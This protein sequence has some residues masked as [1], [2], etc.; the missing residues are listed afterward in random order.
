MSAPIRLTAVL[1][2]PVQ[3]LAPLFRYITAQCPSLELTVLYAAI[4]GPEQQGVGFN[5]AFTW[6]VPLTDGY[7]FVVCGDAAGKRFDSDHFFGVDVPDIGERITATRPDVVLVAGWHSIMEVRALRACRR[8]GIPVVYRGDSTLTSGPRRFVWP[9]WRLKTRTMLRMFDGY[10]AVGR[11]ARAYLRDFGVPEPLIF[12]S[13]H[14]VDNDRFIADSD[15]A[16]QS[17]R[18]ARLAALGVSAEDFV[19]GFAGKLVERKQP[20]AAVRA[21]A[22]LGR[23]AVL[24]VIG[25]GP[26]AE[27]TRAEAARL[28]VRL[29]WRGF[30]NQAELPGALADADAMLVPSTWESWGLAVNE[31]LAAGVPCVATTGVEAARDLIAGGVTGYTVRPRDVRAMTARLADIRWAVEGGRDFLSACRRRVRRNSLKASAD[32]LVSACRRVVARR[33]IAPPRDDVPRVLALCGEMVSVFGRERMTFEVLRVLHEHGAAVHCIVNSWE[34]SPIVAL[35]EILGASWSIGRYQE[36][37]RR[38]GWSVSTVARMAWDVIATC[39]QLLRDVRRQRT[40][41]VFVAGFASVLHNWPVLVAL[42]A[43]GVPVIFRL[44]DPPDEGRFYC[45]LWRW[46]INPAVSAFVANSEYSASEVVRTGI[47]RRKVH[48]IV[49]VPPR[50]THSNV[51]LPKRSN[52]IIYVGQMIPPKGLD[53]L[54]D[55]VGILAARGHDI[56]LDAVGDIDGWEPGGWTG[57]RASLRA[58]AALPDLAG[59]VRFL[60]LR[61]DV[62]SLMAAAAVHCCPS[63]REKRESTGGV[64]IEAKQAGIPSVV[65]PYGGL[66]EH[67]DHKRNGWIARADTP[68]ALAEGI[69]YFMENPVLRQEAAAAA[70]ASASNYRYDRFVAAWLTRFGIPPDMVHQSQEGAPDG[71]A[72]HGHA[73]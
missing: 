65:T 21:V 1:S 28:G 63:R 62:P 8:L 52:C 37:F 2:H 30:L 32:G 5:R 48:V 11:R 60:G 29:V 61:E 42:R 57:Y 31:A 18:A 59:R 25:D 16:R 19:V 66:P 64:T 3:Y 35:A 73:R 45:R 70:G 4:P 14:S 72:V 10:L 56:M 43:A 51:V 24:M 9:L 68:E 15:A 13:P 34:S 71:R 39:A 58:R 36:S 46:L 38:R 6:D 40:T 7:R 49:N 22:G 69:E 23:S 55:A 47:P 26:L 54:L 67:I 53:V 33:R 50:R 20:L 44:G 27:A 41:H 12:D 17:D